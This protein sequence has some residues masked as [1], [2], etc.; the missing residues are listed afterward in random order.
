MPA[1]AATH[2]CIGEVVSSGER[3]DDR[4]QGGGLGGVAF[5]TADLQGEP[6]A[7]DQQTDDDL[8]VD[9]AFLGVPDLA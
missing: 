9:A 3:G 4:H 2:R 1:S 8:R 5:K 7:I 6:G